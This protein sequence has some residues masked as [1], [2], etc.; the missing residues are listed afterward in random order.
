M[1]VN[2][3]N[4]LIAL[5]HQDGKNFRVYMHS[6]ETAKHLI[7]TFTQIRVKFTVLVIL[8]TNYNQII[9]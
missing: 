4:H 3:P 7:H 8:Y 5:F 1:D 6:Q 9:K 2:R